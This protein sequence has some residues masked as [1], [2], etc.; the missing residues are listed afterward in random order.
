MGKRVV[1][2]IHHESS[3][4]DR[5]SARFA[6]LGYD[7]DWREPFAGDDLGEP[8]ES[9]AATV[10]YGGGE[11]SD[12]RDWHT[13]R[14]PWIAAETAWVQA[15]MAR[16]IP[17]LGIC[18]G[19]CIISHALGAVIGPP[20]HGL[21]EFGYYALRVTAEGRRKDHGEIPDGLIVTQAHYHGFDLPDGAVRLAASDSYPNQAYRYGETTYA[22]QFHPEVTP[23]GF[24]RWQD[25]D[26]A[27][28]GKPGAQTREQQDRLRAAHDPAQAE[29]IAGFIDRLMAQE[30]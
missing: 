11:P 30:D 10:L 17:T 14:F 26:W 27:H 29:W 23:Q 3:K 28:W 4:D 20:D 2:I 19:G 5:V 1:L 6:A 12:A 25:G 13:D 7:L 15:C 8:D 24:R 16:H 18:L 21:H 9:V 22:F